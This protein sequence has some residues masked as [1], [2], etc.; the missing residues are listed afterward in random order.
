MAAKC[1]F[2]HG[3][4]LPPCLHTVQM[5]GVRILGWGIE[6]G[7]EARSPACQPASRGASAA[8]VRVRSRMT[9]R[10]SPPLADSPDALH[11]AEAGSS[12]CAASRSR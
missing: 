4:W 12:I 8:G 9:L 6:R 10:G 7:A 11:F 1:T 5:W 2:M 3:I